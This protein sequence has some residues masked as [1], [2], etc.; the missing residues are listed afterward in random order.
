MNL[1]RVMRFLLAKW[2]NKHFADWCWADLVTWAMGDISLRE[3]LDEHHQS[4]AEEEG[5]WCGKC[6]ITGRLSH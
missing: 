4:C 3:L 5:S 1:S 2:L 6:R